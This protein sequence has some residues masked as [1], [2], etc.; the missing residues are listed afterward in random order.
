MQRLTLKVLL[1]LAAAGIGGCG[2]S[3]AVSGTAPEGD[4]RPFEEFLSALE[5]TLV[6]V[7]E[8]ERMGGGIRDRM[9]LVD[10]ETLVK[11]EDEMRLHQALRL[12][13]GKI[14]S[15]RSSLAS[16]EMVKEVL[17][18]NQR[19]LQEVVAVDA[20]SQGAVIVYYDQP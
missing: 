9:I 8:L 1:V 10:V 6:E 11:G 5:N 20:K 14:R 16:N 2:G 15:L 19:E 17:N 13:Y 3:P 7:N 18:R 4:R 12:N